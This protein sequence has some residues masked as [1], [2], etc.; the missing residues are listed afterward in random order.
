M[1]NKQNER[2]DELKKE[3]RR[4]M[5]SWEPEMSAWDAGRFIVHLIN[6]LKDEDEENVWS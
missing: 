4:A 6:I 3:I 5:K 1:E 2:L